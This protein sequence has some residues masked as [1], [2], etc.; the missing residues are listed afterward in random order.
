MGFSLLHCAAKGENTT[1][2]NKLLSL[3]LHIDSR[4]NT[5][6]TPLMTA[7]F[8][9]KQSAFQML[10]QNGADPHL[11]DSDGYSLLHY[12]AQGGT[13]FIMNKLL[14]L[15]LEINSKDLNGKTPLIVAIEENN[16]KAVKFLMSKG[17][18]NSA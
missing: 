5:G 9:D 8:C 10:I 17:A 1:I 11:K 15:G 2:I 16:S 6:V 12:A 14:S 3:G 18:L 7:A 4:N 13:T